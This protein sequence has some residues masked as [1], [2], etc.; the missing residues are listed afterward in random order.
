ML[1][2]L[3]R[4]IPMSP[5]CLVIYKSLLLIIAGVGGSPHLFYFLQSCLS[6]QQIHSIV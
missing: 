2:I 4:E 3:L 5:V 1:L 6:S